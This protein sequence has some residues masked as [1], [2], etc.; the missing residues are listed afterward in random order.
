MGWLSKHWG[1]WEKRLAD[2]FRTCF[3]HLIGR[4]LLCSEY[5]LVSSQS[6]G[7]QISLHSMPIWRD[8]AIEW[9]G[10]KVCL[11]FL[12]ISY[13]NPNELFG[14][15][16]NSS[17]DLVVTNPPTYSFHTL[18]MNS[19][20]PYL[21]P[22]LSPDKAGKVSLRVLPT[23]RSFFHCPSGPPLRGAVGLL[24][25]PFC[26]RQQIIQKLLQTRPG[27][28]FSSQLSDHKELSVKP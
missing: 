11:D 8:P 24:L 2:I 15:P 4:T 25:S 20:N 14:Q 5:S 6:H 9:A 17:P 22:S 3:V 10:Q 7:A 16:N 13:G 21:W 12:K 26:W 23:R 18:P 27:L 1:V 19:I 28:F